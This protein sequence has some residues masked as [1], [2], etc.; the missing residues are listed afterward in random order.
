M[1][2]AV[3][4]STAFLMML[5]SPARN[6][7]VAVFVP[8]GRMALTNYLSATLIVVACAPYIGLSRGVS[9]R[10]GMMLAL[11]TAILVA[12]AVFSRLWLSRY[13]HGPVEWILRCLTWR[14]RTPLR[15]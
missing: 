6:P 8:L 14:S 3:A 15:L 2:S 12:Q 5:R 11:A 4:Y 9:G 13:R 7:L 10:Y 1:L